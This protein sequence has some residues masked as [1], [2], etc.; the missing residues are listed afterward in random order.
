MKL[1]TLNKYKGKEIYISY[2]GDADKSTKE[3]NKGILEDIDTE[4]ITIVHKTGFINIPLERIISV[5]D[6]LKYNAA[7]V[8]KT[9]D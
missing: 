7:A 4:E 1:S 5:D 9:V 8:G 3:E 6:V 2:W